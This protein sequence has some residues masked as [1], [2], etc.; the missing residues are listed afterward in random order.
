MPV[1]DSCRECALDEGAGTAMAADVMRQMGLDMPD[2][3][4][5]A[6]ESDGQTECSCQCRQE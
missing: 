2:H 6:V 1:C 5:A 4:C 3:L